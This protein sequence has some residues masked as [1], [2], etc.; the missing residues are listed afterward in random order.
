[1]NAS[2]LGLIGDVGATNARFALVHA[3]GT[4]A[5]ARPAL[6]ERIVPILIDR[7]APLRYASAISI[8]EIE[9]GAL[10]MRTG[11]RRKAQ[12]SAHG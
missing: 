7:G 12:F 10:Q 5:S 3:D 8:L 1:M 11:T 4:T 6:R 9:L 2:E